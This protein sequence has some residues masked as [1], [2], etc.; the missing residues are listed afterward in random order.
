MRRVIVRYK[1][2]PERLEEHEALI[3]AVYE[4]LARTKPAGLRYAAFK[5]GLSFTHV[6]F[7]EGTS[8]PLNDSPA[9]KAFTSN[10]GERVDEKPVTTDVTEVGSY[11]F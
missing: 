4:E 3:R 9:F 10:I 11:S 6:S 5:D 8:N 7:I 2:K 1:V